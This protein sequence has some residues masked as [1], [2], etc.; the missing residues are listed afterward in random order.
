VRAER[1]DTQISNVFGWDYE[2]KSRSGEK[3]GENRQQK[4]ETVGQPMSNA[5]D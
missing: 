4:A 5:K 1:R 3:G 2:K